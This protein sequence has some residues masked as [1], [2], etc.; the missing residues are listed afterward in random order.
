MSSP[1]RQLLDEQLRQADAYLAAFRNT[2]EAN[3]IRV[4]IFGGM[5]VHL[6]LERRGVESRLS[7]DIDIHARLDARLVAG[8][9]H[10]FQLSDPQAF[11]S[12]DWQSRLIP[13]LEPA[14]LVAI[15]LFCTAPVDLIVMKIGRSWEKDIADAMALMNAYGIEQIEIA[16]LVD[17]A[18]R[19]SI[20]N[21]SL[22]SA[23][24]RGMLE[25]FDIDWVPPAD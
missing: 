17:E 24:Q 11:C 14:G 22:R 8:L 4:V 7:M 18:W 2:S 20:Q 10:A 23:V 6:N 16:D 25:L 1:N 15:D 13:M 9:P 19:Y 3:R 12:P 5:A 21:P